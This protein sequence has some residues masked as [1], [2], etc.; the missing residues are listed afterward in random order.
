MK[1]SLIVASLSIFA[2]LAG[3]TES[4]GGESSGTTTDSTSTSTSDS[5]SS[6]SDTGPVSTPAS[7]TIENA[8]AGGLVVRAGIELP[9]A[10]VDP[11]T[12][13]AHIL[14][15]ECPCTM[16]GSGVSCSSKDYLGAVVVLPA[17]QS[18][19]IDAPIKDFLPQPYDQSTC[20]ELLY[21]GDD[22]NCLQPHAL[23]EGSYSLQVQYDTEQIIQD[24]GLQMGGTQWGQQVWNGA[25]FGQ[26]P[27][28]QTAYLPFSVSSGPLSVHITLTQ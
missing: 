5:T 26:I 22:Q 12:Y 13:A 19:T 8:T 21:S 23:A 14:Y 18:I 28:A 10:V 17:G 3:C 7:I 24:Q 4:T 11:D 6:S 16:C 20:V 9:Y 27:L 25:L 15:A 1:T 2:L